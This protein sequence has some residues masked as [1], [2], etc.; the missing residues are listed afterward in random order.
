MLFRSR[1]GELSF[2]NLRA[3]GWWTLRERL[4]P[5]SKLKPLALPPDDY[6]IGDLTAPRWH[7]QTA[8]LQIEPKDEIRKRL[9]RSTDVGDAIV[10]A[11]SAPLLKDPYDPIMYPHFY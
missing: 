6:L 2:A 9:G 1:S 11:L 10:H 8:G 5:M 7:R 4:D 3:A